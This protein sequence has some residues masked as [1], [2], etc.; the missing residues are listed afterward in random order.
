MIKATNYKLVWTIICDKNGPKAIGGVIGGVHSGCSEETTSLFLEA[1]YF[2]PIRT[3]QTARLLNIITDARYR[4]ERGVDPDFVSRGMD[5]ATQLILDI[6]GGETSVPVI[7]GQVPHWQRCYQLHQNQCLSLAGMDIPAE[8]QVQ[9]LT[10]LGFTVTAID[11]TNNC[12]DVTP[13]SW[14]Q[15]IQTQAHLVKEIIRIR[16]YDHLAQTALPRQN[17]VTQAVLTDLQYRQKQAQRCLANRGLSET[18]TFSFMSSDL[19]PLFHKT[20]HPDTGLR[21]L[22]PISTDLNEMR[23]SI[24]PN[25]LQAMQRNISRGLNNSG[26][27]E[28]GAQYQDATPTGQ[29]SVISGIRFGQTHGRHWKEKQ[30]LIDAYDAKADVLE[31]LRAAAGPADS[32]Q[33]TS[34]AP[35][36]YHPGR[37]GAVALGKNVL[38]YFG[39]IHPIILKKMD[40]NET[41]VGFEVFLDNIPGR[42]DQQSATR[43]MPNMSNLQRVERDFAFSLDCSIPSDKLIRL[44]KSAD[45][46]LISDV[47]LFDVYQGKGIAEGQKSLAVMVSLQP[48]DE[49]LT[50]VDI[51]KISDKIIERAGKAGASLRS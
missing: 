46:K 43:T 8:T 23:P 50:D 5:I 25:L 17:T 27:F 37:S 34:Q 21:L 30:R 22:N 20:G 49:T 33:I 9:I 6:C 24:L 3:A 15:D 35:R 12:W 16:G 2:D 32:A 26:L 28:I 48:K 11:S 44:I 38:A 42:K 10:N 51:K 4:F 45:K 40:I 14:R 47:T 39:E 1:A 29:Q 13:P 31:A 36:W 18:V 7:A 19:T 41:V